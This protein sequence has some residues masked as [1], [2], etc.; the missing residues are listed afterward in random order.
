MLEASVPYA[1]GCTVRTAPIFEAPPGSACECA[2]GAWPEPRH[3]AFVPPCDQRMID[4]HIMNLEKLLW[5][6]VRHCE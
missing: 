5:S 3:W 1:T 6:F 2:S 4:R